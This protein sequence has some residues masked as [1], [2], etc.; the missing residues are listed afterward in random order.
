MKKFLQAKISLVLTIVLVVAAVGGTWGIT[1]SATRPEPQQTVAGE[2]NAPKTAEELYAEAVEDAMTVESDEVLPLVS[3]DEGAPYAVYDD[4]GRVLMFTYHKYPDSYPNGAD[5]KIEWGEVWTFT[6]GELADW[7]KENKD[8]VT[9]WPA[10][11]KQLIG[12][13]PDNEN[14][15]FTAM[16]VDP[17]D[18]KRPAN[19][20]DTG[21]VTMTAAL[22]ENTDEAFKEWFDGNII[23]SYFDSA[24]PW[25]RLGYT[26]DWAADA[27]DEYGLSEFLVA[28]GSQV[29]VAYTV[30]AEEMLS[31]LEDGSWLPDTNETLQEAA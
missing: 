26:Y 3:L 22:S 31:M 8:D 19:V 30:T 14:T 7:Y 27:K 5:V 24:Y 16:W 9:D 29:E 13:T 12:L 25:T 21:E 23:W 20:Q 2:N 15:H 18:V 1:Y 28:D 17:D 6:G 10:R 4:E 11:L